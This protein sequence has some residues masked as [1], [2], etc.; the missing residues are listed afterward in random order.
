MAIPSS[1]SDAVISAS[2]SRRSSPST[3]A[4]RRSTP[5]HAD[6]C[7]HRRLPVRLDN[8]ANATA[9]LQTAIDNGVDAVYPYPR[10]RVAAC[11]AGSERCWNHHHERRFFEGLRRRR[12]P[13]VDIA[14]RFD[15]GDYVSAVMDEIIAGT[16]KE[17]DIKTFKVGVDPEPGALICNATPENKRK[18]TAMYAQ[19]A[20]A[21]SLM[22]SA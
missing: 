16:F 10:R 17:G 12:W 15:A 3:S 18:W 11:R 4:C 9:A 7:R 20:P 8:S 14:V 13:D 2:R 21:I 5:L 1:S 22:S 6:V 19:I